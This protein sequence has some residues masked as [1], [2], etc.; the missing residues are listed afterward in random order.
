MYHVQT[1][2]HSKTWYRVGIDVVNWPKNTWAVISLLKT[3]VCLCVRVNL[4]SSSWLDSCRKVIKNGHQ[5]FFSPL[6][7]CFCKLLSLQGGD[8]PSGGKG[9]IKV[10]FYQH[11]YHTG[12]I[13]FP[14]RH[15]HLHLPR[16]H[17]VS[18]P[19][20][21]QCFQKSKA[22]AVGDFGGKRRESLV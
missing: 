6:S 3:S 18:A 20:W 7:R 9:R 19:K 8:S 10:G 11:M 4:L 13:S 22:A 15:T 21:Q 2:I 5:M 14:L 1:P 12:C 16:H 17:N